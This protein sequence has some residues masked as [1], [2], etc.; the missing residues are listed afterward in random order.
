MLLPGIKVN[1]GPDDHR[2]L[3]DMQLVV[4]QNE[5]WIAMGE[6]ISGQIKE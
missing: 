5:R 4:F 1:T 2:P 6:I 3:E